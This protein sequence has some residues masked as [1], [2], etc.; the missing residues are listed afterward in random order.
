M[1]RIIA[2]SIS[3]TTALHTSRSAVYSFAQATAWLPTVCVRWGP[4]LLRLRDYCL[5]P[6][7][8]PITADGILRSPD[9]MRCVLNAGF[10]TEL[11]TLPRTCLR[12]LSRFRCTITLRA[13]AGDNGGFD[14]YR[15]SLDMWLA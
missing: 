10:W 7:G 5:S 9:S 2:C 1:V 15:G 14:V 11:K 4:W 8:L 6:G 3:A 13:L 12:G